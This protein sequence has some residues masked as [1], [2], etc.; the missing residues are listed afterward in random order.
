VRVLNCCAAGSVKLWVK[1][2]ECRLCEALGLR[3]FALKGSA[4]LLG[5]DS[6]GV[7]VMRLTGPR[8]TRLFDYSQNRCPNRCNIFCVHI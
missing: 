8:L 5:L 6:W 1:L 4:A 7:M 3:S 2:G